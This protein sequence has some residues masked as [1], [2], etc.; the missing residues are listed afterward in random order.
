MDAEI[1][2]ETILV[3]QFAKFEDQNFNGRFP[4]E[5]AI[6]VLATALTVAAPGVSP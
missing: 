5:K 4:Q 3:S 2:E 6:R 1:Y